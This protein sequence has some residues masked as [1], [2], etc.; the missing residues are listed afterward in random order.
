[1]GIAKL[2]Q[3]VD[4]TVNTINS[5]LWKK[6]NE[7]VEVA[8]VLLVAVALL[9]AV[10]VAVVVEVAEEVVEVVFLQYMYGTMKHMLDTMGK[11]QVSKHIPTT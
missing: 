6:P 3:D 2:S 5:T 11:H 10:L 7:L 9:V 1:M 8:V 4:L